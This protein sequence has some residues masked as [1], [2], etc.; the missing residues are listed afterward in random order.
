MILT[1]LCI[2]PLSFVWDWNLTLEISDQMDLKPHT[3]AYLYAHTANATRKPIWHILNF[4]G[5]HALLFVLNVSL[6]RQVLIY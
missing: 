2:Q 3:L 4:S 6:S 5:A 1:G